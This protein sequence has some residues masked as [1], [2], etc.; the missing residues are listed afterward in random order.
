MGLETANNIESLDEANPTP[1]DFVHDAATHLRMIKHVLKKQ[2]PGRSGNGMSN[3]VI[4]AADDLSTL[5][6]I[7]PWL[8][9]KSF[10]TKGTTLLDMLKAI[11]AWAVMV[12][13]RI[14]LGTGTGTKPWELPVGSVYMNYD[15]ARNPSIILGYGKWLEFAR[16]KVLAG[17][18]RNLTPASG[19]P[20][21]MFHK[22]GLE[23]GQTDFEVVDHNHFVQGYTYA[24]NP[25]AQARI[26]VEGTDLAKPSSGAFTSNNGTTAAWKNYPP[27]VTVYMWRRIP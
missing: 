4:A 1:E 6:N 12:S 21:G 10:D 16:N 11:E 23:G 15:D 25:G 2:F 20:Y 3:P 17:V 26:R 7:A 24:A 22:G 19:T 13:A 14:G 18:N 27:F 8:A 5:N 9:G